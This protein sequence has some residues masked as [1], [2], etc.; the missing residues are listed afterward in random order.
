[1]HAEV[2]DSESSR[3]V[4]RYRPNI[5]FIIKANRRVAV[6][7]VIDCFA[8]YTYKHG[9]EN[10]AR[11]Q[12]PSGATLSGPTSHTSLISV[13]KFANMDTARHLIGKLFQNHTVWNGLV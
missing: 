1:M 11:R 9:H 5:R 8:A 3:W 4:G 7:S 10:R 13:H 2:H 12:A 6:K